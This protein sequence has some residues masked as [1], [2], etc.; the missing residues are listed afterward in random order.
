MNKPKI[1]EI[2]AGL[3]QA[4]VNTLV[5]LPFAQVNNL[6]QPLMQALQ[7]QDSAPAESAK[8]AE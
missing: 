2:E 6:M 4:I 1:Y 8:A 3:M 5:A 7:A